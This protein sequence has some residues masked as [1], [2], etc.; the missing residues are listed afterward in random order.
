MSRKLI[1]LGIFAAVF[2]ICSPAA[3]EAAGQGYK[4]GPYMLKHNEAAEAAYDTARGTQTAVYINIECGGPSRLC[5]EIIARGMEHIALIFDFEGQRVLS[6]DPDGKV[7]C[8]P[9]IGALAPR[10]GQ[11][12]GIYL[13]LCGA[14]S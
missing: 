2:L 4:L 12:R 8:T 5:D 7:H 9:G 3:T 10:M 13:A 1:T 6:V 11:Y 14:G